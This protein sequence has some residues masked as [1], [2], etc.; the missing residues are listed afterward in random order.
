[1]TTDIKS[2]DVL[3]VGGSVEIGGWSVRHAVNL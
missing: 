2:V 3:L 1:M